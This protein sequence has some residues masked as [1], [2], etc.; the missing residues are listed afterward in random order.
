VPLGAVELPVGIQVVGPY[1]E[2]RTSL[3]VA[4]RLAELTGG[5]VPAPIGL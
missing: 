1:L 3:F 4:G 5:Y 2:D